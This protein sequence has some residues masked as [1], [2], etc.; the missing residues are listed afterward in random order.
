[1]LIQKLAV[2]LDETALVA[3]MLVSDNQQRHN[4]GY[5]HAHESVCIS[6]LDE[7]GVKATLTT[8]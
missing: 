6:N 2:P 4:T 3:N 7:N 8:E 1:M 5:A